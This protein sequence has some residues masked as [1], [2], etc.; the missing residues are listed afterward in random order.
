MESDVMIGNL[1][2]LR[3]EIRGGMFEQSLHNLSLYVS[4][5]G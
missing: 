3:G 5:L 1:M 4:A 2:V